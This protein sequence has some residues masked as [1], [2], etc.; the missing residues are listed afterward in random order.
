MHPPDISGVSFGLVAVLSAT[1][2]MLSVSVDRVAVAVTRVLQ[3]VWMLCVNHRLDRVL[4]GLFQHDWKKKD[5]QNQ[6]L[7]LRETFIWK[8]VTQLVHGFRYLHPL[9]ADL[10]PDTTR[11][12]WWTIHHRNYIRVTDD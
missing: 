9:A 2:G 3:T 1:G 12:D 10:L 5:A 4:E 11:L 7:R 6:L 8:F